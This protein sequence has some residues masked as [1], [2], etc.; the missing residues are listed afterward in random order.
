MDDHSAEDQDR[1]EMVHEAR[2]KELAQA[3]VEGRA[4]VVAL[5]ASRTKSAEQARASG[6]SLLMWCAQRT[7]VENILP[8]GIAPPEARTAEHMQL[9]LELGELAGT[10]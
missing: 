2:D 3:T 10:R 9:I 4:Y 1:Q 8:D 5:D 7:T 6:K